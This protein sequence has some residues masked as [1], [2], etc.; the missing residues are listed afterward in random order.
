MA[1]ENYDLHNHSTASD[2]LLSPTQ[3]IELAARTGVDAIA[4]TDHDT[5]DGLE[6]ANA[7]AKRLGISFIPGVEISVSWGDTT[8]HVV[9]LAI[10]AAS[11]GLVA[12]L[13]SIRMGRHRR[14]ERIA[15]AL[16]GLGMENT[17]EG[18]YALAENKDMLGRTH[19][20][21]HLVVTGRVK[22]LQAAFDKYLGKGKPAYVPH[23]WADLGDAV[24]WIRGAGGIAVLAHPGRYDLKPM[25]RDEMLKDFRA[26]GGEAIEVV[27][28]SHR[29]EQ[30]AH[31]QRLALEHGFLASRGADYHGPGESPVEPGRLP[32]LDASLEPVWSR[33]AH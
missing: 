4:L 24:Q 13:R 17:F 28:G 7:A 32:P 9:G 3:L 6:E 31:W 19:F 1:L 21:R 23:R 22:D 25:F 11:P 2:G 18:A 14:G 12:G 16:A 33:W 5:T 15:E 8:L 27:T 20:A 26:A 10:N 30:Y 29:P